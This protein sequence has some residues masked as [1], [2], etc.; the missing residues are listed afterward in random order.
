MYRIKELN[1]FPRL[2]IFKKGI[3]IRHF[4]TTEARLTLLYCCC[5]PPAIPPESTCILYYFLLKLHFTQQQHSIFT[6]TSFT[7][8]FP[9]HTLRLWFIIIITNI[10]NSVS[11]HGTTHFPREG[12]LILPLIWLNFLFWQLVE[13]ASRGCT[14]IS[15]QIFIYI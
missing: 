11:R 15:P 6:I 9:L 5:A 14:L 10:I 13:I 3:G 7:F 12:N 4:P 8:L 1:R 2:H